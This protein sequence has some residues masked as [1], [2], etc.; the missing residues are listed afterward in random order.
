MPMPYTLANTEVEPIKLC[1]DLKVPGSKVTP[2]CIYDPKHV[3][4]YVSG[5]LANTGI[6]EGHL[7][8]VVHE[9][10]IHNPAM[11]FMDIGCNVGVY[12]IAVSHWGRRVVAIDANR[13]NLELL[14]T[15]LEMGKLTQNVTLLWNALSDKAET[16]SLR[17]D[18]AVADKNIGGSH[19]DGN[20]STMVNNIVY[21]VMLDDLVG[22]FAKQPLFIKIDIEASEW[23]A[24]M[25][26]K[27]FFKSVDIKYMLMEWMHYKTHYLHEGDLIVNFL[28]D[29]SFKP[30][31]PQNRTIALETKDSHTSW[32]VDVLW[33][34][35]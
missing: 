7:I 26:G 29:R 14:L 17:L 8:K 9:I 3:D 32:P 16:M 33:I 35:N 5:E 24:L 28:T 15:S 23:K 10:L 22:Y 12:T 34:K 4:I 31:D 20:N 1:V 21:A 27:H 2:I 19:V 6:W 30:F 13:R 11:E 25:G 18:L